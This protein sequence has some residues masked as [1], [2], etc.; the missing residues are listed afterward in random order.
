MRIL[1][2]MYDNRD[3]AAKK[4]QMIAAVMCSVLMI[5]LGMS[6]SLRGVFAPVFKETFGLSNTKVSMIISVSYAGNLIFLFIGGKLLDTFKKKTVMLCTLLMWMSALLLYFFTKSYTLLLCGMI[7][8][9]GASTLLST[10]VN[11]ITP[12]L[13]MSPGLM[14]NLFNFTQGVGISGGQNQ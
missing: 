3:K 6:D 14:M 2:D 10:S 12:I 11:I 1:T 8:S 5:V 9:M 7:F 13:F 4:N